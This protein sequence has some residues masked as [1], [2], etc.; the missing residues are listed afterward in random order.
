M[1]RKMN[2]NIKRHLIDEVYDR[3]KERIINLELKPGSRLLLRQMADQLGVSQTPI[4]EALSKLSK[5]GLVDVVAGLGYYVV[6]LSSRDVREIYDLRKIYENYVLDFAVKNLG[7]DELQTM[8]QK[9]NECKKEFDKDKKTS[10]FYETDEDFHMRIIQ[11]SDNRKL[12]EVYT[13]IYDLVTVCRHMYQRTTEAIEEHL[14]LIDAL[15]DKDLTR[16]KDALNTHIN[17]ARDGVLKG[18]KEMEG[19]TDENFKYAKEKA[20]SLSLMGGERIGRP[21]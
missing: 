11:N 19:K 6:E 13:R 16:A 7:S 17:N 15:T 21:V 8:K 20:R 5:D 12:K 14:T 1:K 18:L 3:I 9:L 2:I 10:Q 4:R